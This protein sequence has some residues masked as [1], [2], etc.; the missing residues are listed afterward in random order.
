MHVVRCKRGSR[1]IRILR[2]EHD[3][4]GRTCV[5]ETDQLHDGAEPGGIELA[6]ARLIGRPGIQGFNLQRGRRWLAG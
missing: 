6:K 5:L 3:T 1:E 2:R 4:Y